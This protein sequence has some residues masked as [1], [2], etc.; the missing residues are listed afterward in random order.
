MR[1]SLTAALCAVVASLALATGAQ[2]KSVSGTNG[3]D[4]LSGTASA[5]A[6]KAKGGNDRVQ[7]RGGDDRVNAGKGRDRVN[8]GG[9]D[10]VVQA[11]DGSRG[12]RDLRRRR[13]HGQAGRRRRDR[14]RHGRR[15]QRLVRGRAAAGRAGASRTRTRTSSRESRDGRDCPA[16]EEEPAGEQAVLGA[17]AQPGGPAGSDSKVWPAHRRACSR[18]TPYA[19]RGASD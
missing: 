9:G 4:R 5:D 15:R 7:A 14:R 2:A 16:K 6:I 19:C 12:P 1:T 10:D 3:G 8:A 13:R 18:T 11:R 17:L